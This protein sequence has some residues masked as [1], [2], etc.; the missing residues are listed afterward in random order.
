MESETT[1]IIQIIPAEGW[2]ALFVTKDGDEERPYT[3]PLACWALV[4]HSAEE[5]EFEDYDE[6]DFEGEDFQ[7]EAEPEAVEEG[8]EEEEQQEEEDEDFDQ[9]DFEE[10]P[11]TYRAV[12]GIAAFFGGGTCFVED[13]PG[14]VCYLEP[15]EEPEKRYQAM[16]DAGLVDESDIPSAED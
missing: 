16:K 2:R 8:E 12:E 7:G 4:E 10:E 13:L 3:M 14:Y 6:E 1:R 15:G 11:A 9:E 5:Y